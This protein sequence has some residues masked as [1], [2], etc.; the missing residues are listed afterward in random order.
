MW[1][2]GVVYR[3]HTADFRKYLVEEVG[4]QDKKRLDILSDLEKHRQSVLE[5]SMKFEQSTCEGDKLTIALK[6]F[7]KTY[8]G[9]TR[10]SVMELMRQSLQQQEEAEA[11]AREKSRKEE[12]AKSLSKVGLL[13]DKAR[14]K[15]YAHRSSEERRFM[16]LDMILRR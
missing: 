8:E 3:T 11:A 4:N 7:K 14:L 1:T 5:C 12:E 10:Y 16:A 13:A 9:A 6:I 15:D 2:E